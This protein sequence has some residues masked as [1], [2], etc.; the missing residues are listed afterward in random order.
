MSMA[1]QIGILRG[2]I[3]LPKTSVRKTTLN[4][5]NIIDKQMTRE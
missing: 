5:N 1:T 4:Q 2:T 3:S